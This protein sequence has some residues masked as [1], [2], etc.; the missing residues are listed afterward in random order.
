[1]S[2]VQGVSDVRWAGAGST[3]HPGPAAACS[4]EPALCLA[5]R[6]A[7]RDLDPELPTGLSA[8]LF[9]PYSIHMSDT[10]PYIAAWVVIV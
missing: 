5:V 4:P 1:M 8:P 7:Q 6:L 9:L 3:G 2:P 10:V